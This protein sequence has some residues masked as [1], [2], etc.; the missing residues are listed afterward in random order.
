MSVITDKIGKSLGYGRG[1]K[2]SVERDGA[3][4]VV[5]FQPEGHVI[6]RHHDLKALIHVCSK[7][8]WEVVEDKI[9]S[10]EPGRYS[11]VSE[12][13][14]V[15]QRPITERLALAL[16]PLN[17]H[18]PDLGLVTPD[19]LACPDGLGSKHEI[20]D[21]GYALSGLYFKTPLSEMFRTAQ[22]TGYFPRRIVP[23]FNIRLRGGG[24]RL[25]TNERS[26]ISIGNQPEMRGRIAGVNGVA[27]FSQL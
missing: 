3:D 1:R 20:K 21:R 24:C 17:K 10:A 9:V 13:I 22:G 8:R 12:R 2:V 6:F 15:R 27:D 19:G 5:A 26:L 25:S 4:F 16:F 14:G 11:H 18:H 7:L 23:D